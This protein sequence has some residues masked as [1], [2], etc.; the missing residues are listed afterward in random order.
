MDI[1]SQGP[2]TSFM[3]EAKLQPQTSHIVGF[4]YFYSQNWIHSL[5]LFDCR[6]LSY[7]VK[8]R[9]FDFGFR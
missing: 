5:A 2:E 3:S 1:S 9:K 7:D 4:D 6:R 8:M